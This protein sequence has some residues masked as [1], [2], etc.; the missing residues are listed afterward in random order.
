MGKHGIYFNKLYAITNMPINRFKQDLERL[1]GYEDYM[2]KLV[3]AFNP[4]AAES[5][6]C[7]NLISVGYD[8]KIY[9]CDFNQMLDMQV[10]GGEP[11]TVFNFDFARLANRRIEFASHCFGC[12]AGAGSSCGGQTV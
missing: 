1:G 2:E 10:G 11:A 9:D 6:M 7:R 5:V 3:N 8:G 12:A 4:A